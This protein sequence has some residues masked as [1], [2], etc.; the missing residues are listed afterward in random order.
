MLKFHFHLVLDLDHTSEFLFLTLRLTFG[1]N[2]PYVKTRSDHPPLS[3][4]NIYQKF[5]IPVTNKIQK[6]ATFSKISHSNIK[7]DWKVLEE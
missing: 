1:W 5:G 3:I 4:C 2:H 7:F 6:L